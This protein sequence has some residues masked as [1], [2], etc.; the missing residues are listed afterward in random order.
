MVSKQNLKILTK[1]LFFLCALQEFVLHYRLR[2]QWPPQKFLHI[3]FTTTFSPG[4]SI[5]NSA[6]LFI[7]SEVFS[8]L[9]KQMHLNNL[10]VKL[11]KFF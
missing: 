2:S 6:H 1:L 5:F 4:I 7:L 10:I 3:F 8:T 9:V 11:R